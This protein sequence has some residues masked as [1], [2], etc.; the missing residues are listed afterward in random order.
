MK[1]YY[2]I[3]CMRVVGLRPD[4]ANYNW[5]WYRAQSILRAWLHDK[6][7]AEIW[8]GASE[9]ENVRW[10]SMWGGWRCTITAVSA[11]MIIYGYIH[12]EH[13]AKPVPI[14]SQGAGWKE[15]LVQI[16]ISYAPWLQAALIPKCHI[17]LAATEVALWLLISPP[18]VIS[19]SDTNNCFSSP[20]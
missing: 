8:G 3:I 19:V 20:S 1:T 15:P 4:K 18:K 13:R 7:A 10:K 5:T 17:L 9:R 12:Y 11:G 16:Q 14:W 6:V 2:H